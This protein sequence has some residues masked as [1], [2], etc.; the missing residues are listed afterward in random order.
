MKRTF[1]FGNIDY[2]GNGIA[3]NRVTVDMEYQEHDGKK[4]FSVSANVW[5]ARHSD[6]V[7]GGQCLDTIA[8][9]MKDLLFFEILRLWKRYHLNDMHPECTHQADAG[10]RE[11]ASKEVPIYHYTM[12]LDAIKA[13]N[14]VKNKVLEAAKHGESC[15]LPEPERVVLALDYSIKTHMPSLPSHLSPYYELKKTETKRLGWLKESEHPDGILSKACPVCGYRYGS[16][17]VYFP[18]PPND[19]AV[20]YTLLKTGKL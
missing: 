12:T 20:I 3:N 4:R 18:I 8:P 1:S 17:W 19:E 6:I 7:A 13:Q 2:T 14:A 5:N 11:I 9:Y 15:K 16:S 10:W